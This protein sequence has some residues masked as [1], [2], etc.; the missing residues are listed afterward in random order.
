MVKDNLSKETVNPEW[1]VSTTFFAVKK[2]DSKIVGIVN[3]RHY[4]NDF[5]KNSGHIGYSV[6]PSERKKGYA[7]E[8]LRQTLEYAK[9]RGL[10]EVYIACKKENE[11]SR[12]TILKN[13]GVLTRTFKDQGKEHEV[14]YIN[15]KRGEI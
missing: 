13:G 5:Y 3:L 4:L 9:Q 12:K 10:K 15:M 2:S 6:R 8:I 11:G 1:V 14:F 7:T